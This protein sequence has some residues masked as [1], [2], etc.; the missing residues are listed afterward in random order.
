VSAGTSDATQLA[1]IGCGTDNTS[2]DLSGGTGAYYALYAPNHNLTLT[3]GSDIWGA[4]V[5]DF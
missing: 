2:W 5:A 1:V 4:I 3:G